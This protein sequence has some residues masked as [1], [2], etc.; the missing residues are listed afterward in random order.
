MG[1]ALPGT[2]GQRL[3]DLLTRTQWYVAAMDRMRVAHMSAH[4]RAGEGVLIFDDTGLPKKGDA[5]VGGDRLYSGTLGR[6][7]NCQVLASSHCVI[8]R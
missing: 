7:D 5:S 8:P 3:H 2:N 1:E 4:A 6:V